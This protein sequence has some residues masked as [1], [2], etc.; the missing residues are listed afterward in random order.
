MTTAYSERAPK[1]LQGA[2]VLENSEIHNLSNVNY[3]PIQLANL[4]TMVQCSQSKIAKSSTDTFSS[5]V[6][7]IQQYSTHLNNTYPRSNVMYKTSVYKIIAP[8]GQLNR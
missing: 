2:D 3:M 8:E 7:Y 5:S 6:R 1:N 4:K